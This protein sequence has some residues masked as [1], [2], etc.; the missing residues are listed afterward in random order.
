MRGAA[1]IVGHFSFKNQLLLIVCGY[2]GYDTPKGSQD[3]NDFRTVF[4]LIDFDAD[5][6]VEKC[7]DLRVCY[8]ALG[9]QWPNLNMDPLIKC[10]V[11][12]IIENEA[13]SRVYWTDNKNPLRTFSLNDP[14]LD[15]LEIG[16]L[17]ISPKSNH[18][19]IALQKTISGSLPVGVY[20][21]CYKYLTDSGGESGISPFSNLYHIS[22]ASNASSALYYGGDPGEQSSDGFLLKITDLDLRYDSILIYAIYY[23]SLGSTPMVSEVIEKNINAN[24]EVS[25][26]HTSL[27]TVIENGVEN[28]LIPSNTWDICKDIAIKDN[29]LFAANLRSK[30]TL[31]Q[32]KNGM[33]NY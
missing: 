32:K 15:D 31:L 10:R 3:E 28:I 4:F 23:P 17:D 14:N 24:G 33:L 12:G 27:T 13:I 1:N 19:Q 5:G 30:K 9:N 8:T 7:T 22:N 6:N 25:F 16:E 20:Q 26:N 21:Y 29:V 11:E 18:N 2:L